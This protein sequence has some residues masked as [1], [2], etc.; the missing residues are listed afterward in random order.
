MIESNIKSKFQFAK[1]N[2]EIPCEN[3]MMQKTFGNH[4]EFNEFFEKYFRA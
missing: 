2:I 1:H 4:T 3:Q